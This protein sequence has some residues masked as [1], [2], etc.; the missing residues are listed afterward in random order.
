MHQTTLKTGIIGTGKHG[1]RYARHIINDIP[2]LELVA[3][4]RRGST[5]KTQSEEWNCKWY[6][7]WR[8]LVADPS[9][10]A[11]IS[12]VPP[13]LNLQI[14]RECCRW[15]K[16]LLIEK[17][18]AVTGS[19][20]EAIVAMFS[21]SGLPLT[22]AQTLRWN[23][24]VKALKEKF[25]L[26]GACHS[27][28]L[29]QR[30]EPSTL[31]WLEDPAV[32]GA[33]VSLHTAVHLFDAIRFVTGWDILR[34]RSATIS[35]YNPGVE[36]I[37]LAQVDCGKAMGLIDTS[38]VSASRTGYLEF[39]GAKGTLRGDHIHGI[40]DL[41]Q[42][43]ECSCLMKK[44]PG[45]GI[46]YLLEEWQDFIRDKGQNPVTAEDGAAAVRACH[47]SLRSASSGKW[48]NT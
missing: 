34:V 8:D 16:P 37:L 10:E 21:Q 32:A 42:G 29:T 25:D 17:P 39:V 19:D 35:V 13:T 31:P 24:V 46:L 4:S 3:I 28:I 26:V 6:Q 1:S 2:G 47:A 12:V 41:F 14:A 22:V 27:F 23:P 30:I 38:K 11:V 18:L 20:A 15:K 48:E 9:V 43:M 33:G 44:A 7:D 45:P 36:D 5:G 40:L